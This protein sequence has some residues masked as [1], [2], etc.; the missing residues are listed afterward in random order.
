MAKMTENLRTKKYIYKII[1]QMLLIIYC[2]NKSQINNNIYTV[3]FEK[4]NF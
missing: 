2:L 1:F 4:N 3:E